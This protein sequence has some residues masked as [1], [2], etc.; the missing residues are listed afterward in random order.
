MLENFDKYFDKETTNMH[1]YF[2]PQYESAKVYKPK[3]GTWLFEWYNLHPK[4]NKLQRVRKT[5]N[6]NRI[7]STAERKRVAVNIVRHLNKALANGW[8]YFVH[9]LGITGEAENPY[10][11]T[12][13]DAI[14]IALKERKIGRK[15]RT[16]ESYDSFYNIFSA[17]LIDNG[18]KDLPI[19]V[20]THN[21][22]SKFLQERSESG[23]SNRNVNDYINFYKTTFDIIVDKEIINKNPIGKIRFLPKVESTKFKT[24][25]KEELKKIAITLKAHNINYYLATKFLA[26]MYIRPGH[27]CDIKNTF[28]DFEN[29]TINLPGYMTKNGKNA[30]KQLFPEVVQLLKKLKIDKL[31]GEWYVFGKH[32][33]P[34][35]KKHAR[36]SKDASG[37]WNKIVIKTL[38]INKHLY[39]L[40]HTSATYI[41]NENE[42]IDT[43]WLKQQMEHHSIEQTETYINERKTKQLDASKVKRIQY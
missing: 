9:E 23:Y 12:T 4:T 22:F 30:T 21:I 6:I 43:G 3:S 34:S 40:K 33:E 24:I 37:L 41:V 1:G 5:F 29:E 26:D 14:A 32:F 36:L 17:W 39:G 10:N 20:F 11:P 18:Y 28:I 38:G 25:T 35:K 16:Q 15:K 42:N 8:N 7:K 27:W 13:V 2:L 19:K 31:R